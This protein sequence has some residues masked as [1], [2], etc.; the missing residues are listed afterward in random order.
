MKKQSD[1]EQHQQLNLETGQLYWEELQRHF[2]RGVVINVNIELDLVEVALK[3]TQDDKETIETWLNNKL[4]A[5]ASDDD[6]KQWEKTKAS[7]WAIVVA[8]WVIV[9]EITEQ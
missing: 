6:A 4:V 2:A 8:P 3:F 1:D 9:Q 5:R 7:F